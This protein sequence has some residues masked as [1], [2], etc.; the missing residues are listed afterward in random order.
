MF[1]IKQIL[2]SDYTPHSC[3]V[4]HHSLRK[5]REFWESIKGRTSFNKVDQIFKFTV[6]LVAGMH[7][8]MHSHRERPVVRNLNAGVHMTLWCERLRSYKSQS[9]NS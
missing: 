8:R 4:R 6:T 2:R 9:R 1:R 5:W 3:L 7:R